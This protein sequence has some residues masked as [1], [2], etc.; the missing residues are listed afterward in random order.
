M[1]LFE[2]AWI[3]D[4]I[5]NLNG[6]SIRTESFPIGKGVMTDAFKQA[7]ESGPMVTHP[8]F[9]HIVEKVKKRGFYIHNVKGNT[10]MKFIWRV[11]EETVY[12]K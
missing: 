3:L 1:S 2:K 12:K 9:S 10:D 11:R 5:A 6:S 8:E 4:I 7:I